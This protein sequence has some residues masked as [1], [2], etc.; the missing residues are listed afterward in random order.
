MGTKT[1][2]ETTNLHNAKIECLR[3]EI[4][5]LM[6]F[7]EEMFELGIGLEIDILIELKEEML[8][9]TLKSESRKTVLE[10]TRQL[11]VGDLVINKE[12][13]SCDVRFVEEVDRDE[14]GLHSIL[15]VNGRQDELYSDDADSMRDGD[16]LDFYD[17]YTILAKKEDLLH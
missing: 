10:K 15:L 14:E 5:I 12:K 1:C 17:K 3:K 9:L 11:N 13:H 7:K 8:E 2:G 4:D 16:M 6:G